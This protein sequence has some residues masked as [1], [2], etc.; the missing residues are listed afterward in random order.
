MALSRVD[1]VITTLGR[2][3]LARALASATAQGPTV[4]KIIVVLDDPSSEKQV[5]QVVGDRATLIT[6]SGR[7]G[8][9]AARN[10]GTDACSSRYVAYLD[11]DDEWEAEKCADQVVAMERTGATWSTTDA[12]IVRANGSRAAVPKGPFPSATSEVISYMLLRPQ[13]RYGWGVIQ[14]S[15]LMVEVSLARTVRWNETLR[16]HQDW[17]FIA[18]LARESGGAPLRVPGVLTSIHQGSAG[19]VSKSANWAES[20]RWVSSLDPLPSPR[21]T[22]DFVATQVLRPA[23]AALSIKGI[24]AAIMKMRGARPHLAALLVGLSGIVGSFHRPQARR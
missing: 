20:L 14:T 7:V 23:L 22:G 15:C 6:T 12:E 18:R 9:G 1:V 19:S 10:I 2:P 24:V 13:L 16:K 3:E 11:D 21:A 5:R 8:G 17:D 4:G